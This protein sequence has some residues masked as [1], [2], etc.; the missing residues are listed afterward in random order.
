MLYSYCFSNVSVF[1][2]RKVQQ[3][4]G[5]R[6]YQPVVHSVDV[7]LLGEKGTIYE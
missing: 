7:N 2:V 4:K 3:S 1:N 6:I 5:I